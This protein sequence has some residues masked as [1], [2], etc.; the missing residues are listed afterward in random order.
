MQYRI[1]SVKTPSRICQLSNKLLPLVSRVKK[2]LQIN[3]PLIRH[4][5]KDVEQLKESENTDIEDF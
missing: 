1:N 5:E 4:M 3:P 2:S